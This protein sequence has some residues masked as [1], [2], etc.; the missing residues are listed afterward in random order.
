MST[1]D[2]KDFSSASVFLKIRMSGGVWHRIANTTCRGRRIRKCWYA[3][4]G[5]KFVT[6]VDSNGTPI[7][8][9]NTTSRS[10]AKLSTISICSKEPCYVE[11]VRSVDSMLKKF[12]VATICAVV[13]AI[14]NFVGC[15]SE[16]TASITISHGTY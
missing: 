16:D 13:S 1:E 2:M 11:S 5:N 7:P 9:R 14:T 15:V 4:A 3:N 8:V 10:T 12:Q 6:I